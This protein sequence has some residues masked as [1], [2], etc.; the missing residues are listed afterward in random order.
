MPRSG[1]CFVAILLIFSLIITFSNTA[2]ADDEIVFEKDFTI[3]KW[4]LYA[5]RHTF[6]ADAAG[7]GILKIRK[8]DHQKEIRRGFFV[9]NGSFTFLRDFLTG[10]EIAFE[11]HITGQK[12]SDWSGF[13]D[14]ISSSDKCSGLIEFAKDQASIAVEKCA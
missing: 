8:N 1:R 3:S 13:Q 11:K 14:F 7:K 2:Y 4:H 10:D 5:S 9:H 12:F 6:S